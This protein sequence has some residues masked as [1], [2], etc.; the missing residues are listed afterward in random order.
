MKEK[1]CGKLYKKQTYNVE[2]KTNSPALWTYLI[3]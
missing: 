2:P 1:M 3:L